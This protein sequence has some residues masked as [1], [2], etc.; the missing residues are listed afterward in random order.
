MPEVCKKSVKI[1]SLLK[2][3]SARHPKFKVLGP[4]LYNPCEYYCIWGEVTGVVSP[5]THYPKP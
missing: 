1:V 3:A 5:E 2:Q 4:L